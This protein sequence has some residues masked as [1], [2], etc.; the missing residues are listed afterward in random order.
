MTAA[1]SPGAI[2][3]VLFDVDGVLTDGSLHIGDSGEHAKVFNV[4]DGIAIG[5]LRTHGI[6]SGV[7]SGKASG[8]LDFRIRQL[9]F[10]AS[11][12]GRLDKL[13]AYAQ[14]LSELG[15]RDEEVAYVGDDVVDLAVMRRVGV[16]YA[17]ADAHALVREQASHVLQARGGQGVAREVAEHVLMAAGMTLAQVYAHM[18]DAD[19]HKAYV[20]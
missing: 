16:S 2:R 6:K 20:Q 18:L 10:D 4:R 13:P 19:W 11:V 9:G 12:T 5:L 17:P 3:L 15:I 1:T 14:M 7:I 8:P